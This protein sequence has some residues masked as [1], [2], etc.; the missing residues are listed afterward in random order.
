M[1]IVFR[2][3]LPNIQPIGAAYFIAFR[4]FGGVLKYPTDLFV[5][6]HEKRKSNL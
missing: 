5:D 6:T 1:K 4:L 3:S 2:R